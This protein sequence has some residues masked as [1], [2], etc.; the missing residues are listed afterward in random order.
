MKRCI[1]VTGGAHGISRAIV[2]AFAYWGDEKIFSD[3]DT[4]LGT[5]TATKTCEATIRMI[6][7]ER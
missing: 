4:R 6:Y 2:E 1:F 7:P 3:I 5:Q